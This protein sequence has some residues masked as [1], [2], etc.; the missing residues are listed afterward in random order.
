M[1]Q[2]TSA[3][4]HAASSAASL[5]GTI[6]WRTGSPCA[7]HDQRGDR[8]ADRVAHLARSESRGVG[9][10]DLVARRDDRDPGTAPDLDAFAAGGRERRDLAHA[11][12]AS[13]RGEHGADSEVVVLAA[14][15]AGPGARGARRARGRARA[16]RCT[17]P[18]RRRRRRPAARRR[19]RPRARC[20]AGARTAGARPC[21]SPRR[22]RAMSAAPRSRRSYRWPSPHTR[23]RRSARSREAPREQ[24]RRSPA[25]ARARRRP[26]RSRSWFAGPDGRCREPPGPAARGTA[27]TRSGSVGCSECAPGTCSPSC[28]STSRD[29]SSTRTR[30]RS[31]T[32]MRAGRPSCGCR[33]AASTASARTSPTTRRPS[34]CCRTR[35]RSSR[36]RARR[37]SRASPGCSTASISRRAAARRRPAPRPTIVAGRS[38]ARRSTSRSARRV[39]HSQELSG[40]RCRPLR[41]GVSFSLGDPPAATRIHDLRARY[42]GTHFKLD[43]TS[44]WTRPLADE[45]HATGA[46][47]VVD[48][49]GYYVGTVV[50]QPADPGAVPADRRRVP[51]RDRRGRGV[52]SRGR[53]DPGSSP[54]PAELRRADP[55]DR[56]RPRAAV[57]AARPELEAVSLR[58]PRAPAR[59]LRLRRRRGHRAVRRR[60]VGARGR[61]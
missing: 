48:L 15:R 24:A 25:R 51:R 43:A 23:R 38:R 37:R 3:S 57:R 17:R 10:H 58:H 40:A 56:R 7:T 9:G 31:P 41:F 26:R 19:S 50:D 52:G 59:L 20:R 27:W 14:R 34:S 1:S 45:L 18:S 29:T 22:S 11:D 55:L 4:R 28:R 12:R 44:A 33:A 13:R 8:G 54:V 21:G 6:P 47:D 53:G 61:P 32:E 60:P 2:S 5:S 30:S 46:V 36:S 42:P 39:S 16:R 35:A 49:K